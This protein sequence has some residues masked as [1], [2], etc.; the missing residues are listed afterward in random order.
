MAWLEL[1]LTGVVELLH[2]DGLELLLIGRCRDLTFK[3]L[4]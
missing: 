1:L 2:L 4:R 3:W